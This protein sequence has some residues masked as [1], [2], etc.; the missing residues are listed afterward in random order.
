MSPAEPHDYLD[1]LTA[2]VSDDPFFLASALAA[3]Q[4]RHGLADIA[5]A[6]ELG[7]VPAVLMSL[8][9]CRRP[10]TAGPDRTVAQD[11]AEIAQ[12]FRINPAVLGQIVG[13][14]SAADVL[15]RPGVP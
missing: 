6:A 8:R 7:C 10:G 14:T 1:T 2:R 3:Y 4:R 15:C 11:I 13:E 12:R 5:L 9:L